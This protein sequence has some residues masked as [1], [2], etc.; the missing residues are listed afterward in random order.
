MRSVIVGVVA[1]TTVAVVTACSG[2]APTAQQPAAQQQDRSAA[3]GASSS[4]KIM[5]MASS[6][7]SSGAGSASS[8]GTATDA[9]LRLQA[10]LGQHSILASE[11]MRARI[12]ADDDLAG[13]ADA[14]LGKNAAAMSDLLTPILPAAARQQFSTAWGEHIQALFN[15]A[16]GL[17]IGDAGVRSTARAELVKYEGELAEF[18]VAHSQRRLDR[19]AALAAVRMHIDQLLAGAD[20][21]A[22]KNY[23]SA[24][25][26]YRLSYSHTFDLGAVLARA[27]LPEK[28]ARELD[29]PA[30]RLRTALTK[31]LG[32]HVGLVIAAMRSAVSDPNGFAAMGA[33]VNGN[34]T[35]LTGAIDSLFGAS[36][37]HGFETLWADHVDLLM[38]YTRSVVRRDAAGQERA[39]LDLRS[40]EQSFAGY[41]SAAT[42]RRLGQPALAQAFVMHDRE[43][44]AEIDAYAAKTFQQA[45]D[46]SDQTYQDM[47][48]VSGQLA[49]AIGATLAGR[50]P[51]G[52]SQTGG[53][54]MAHLVQAR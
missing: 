53:G 14:A 33:A 46:L 47:F 26:T 3:S 10:L 35:D 6:S 15:Y 25:A 11:M 29:T 42:Q 7:A 19:G 22:A 37:A 34:T 9:A 17:S 13:A 20:A 24:A 41:L 16:R 28:A 32:E 31:L 38:A 54:G 2:P 43:L 21:Y 51:R 27:F 49:G 1:V 18:F 39:R 45:H 36:A 40:F 4:A 23:V 52:G 44:L 5:P 30:A 12:R 48:T 50:L 8:S